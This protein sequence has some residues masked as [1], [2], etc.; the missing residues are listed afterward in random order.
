MIV[1]LTNRHF[2][3]LS[4][5]TGTTKAVAALADTL[6][7][8]FTDEG[9]RY[10]HRDAL[11]GLFSEWFSQHTADEVTSALSAT[12]VLWERY[13]TFAET[14]VDERVTNN[15]MFTPLHQPRI[16]RYLAPGL[17][18]QIDGAYPVAVPAPALGDDT[19]AVLGDWL[20][21]TTEEIRGLT[22]SGTV[23]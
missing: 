2:R 14:A 5:L 23:G 17:P 10:R 6:G 9:E 4:E 16:G 21:M 7:A 19:A 1:A 18:L 13:R 20:G 3:D 12:S 8:D 11:S 15:P 22:D